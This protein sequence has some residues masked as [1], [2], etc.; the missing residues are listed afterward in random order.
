MRGAKKVNQSQEVLAET[1]LNLRSSLE[2]EQ[3]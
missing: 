2:I 1:A 3:V